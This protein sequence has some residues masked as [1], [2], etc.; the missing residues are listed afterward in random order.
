ME[1]KLPNLGEGADSG[2]VVN[3]FIK[4]GDT[5]SKDQPLIEIESEKAVASVPSPADGTV[6]KVHVKAGDKL[7]VGQRILTF[8]GAGAPATPAPA[9]GPSVAA[10]PAKAGPVQRPEAEVSEETP[11]EPA[12]AEVAQGPPPP[13]SPS[14]RHVAKELGIDLRRIR[15]SERGGRVVMA[16][17]RGYIQR[18]Q[19][20]AARATAAGPA[21][22]QRAAPVPIDFSRWGPITIKPLSPLRQTIGRRMSESWHAVPRVTQFDEPDMTRLNELRER[23]KAAYEQKGVRLTL[24][25]FLVRCVVLALQKHPVINASLDATGENLVFKDYFHIG[26]AVDTE[27]GL[28]VPIIRDVDKKSL[29]DLSRELEEVSRKA[30]ER[31]VTAEDLRGGTFT[32]SNQGGLGGTHFTPILNLPEVAILGVG[33]G[34]VKPVWREG[35]VEPRHLVPLALSYDHRVIDGGEAARFMVDLAKAALEFDEAFVRL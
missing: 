22:P 26:I 8:A 19:K 3:V 14:V 24:T 11:A 9:A 27:A 15:G 33:R 16:D 7:S 28:I 5:V 6:A 10:T 29:V 2:V 18:L 20:M 34:A 17:L 1:V 32:I 25:G 30:R 21:Q 4:E 12:E 31:K 23:H 13:A 35:R